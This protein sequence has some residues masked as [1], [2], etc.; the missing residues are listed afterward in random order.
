MLIRKTRK[1]SSGGDGSGASPKLGALVKH[2]PRDG[3]SMSYYLRYSV[4]ALTW[5]VCIPGI[6]HVGIPPS[7]SSHATCTQCSSVSTPGV[8]SIT[9]ALQVLEFT[10]IYLST[11][12]PF[13][14]MD[15]P[16][17][18][19]AAQTQPS[20]LLA[21]HEMLIH[22]IHTRQI[23]RILSATISDI[24]A[25]CVRISSS[26]PQNSTMQRREK[27]RTTTI[28]T[29]RMNCPIPLQYVPPAPAATIR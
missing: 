15:A 6:I 9:I 21:N 18:W 8:P 12:W 10:S 28:M 14:V 27:R 22:W 1:R 25:I 23:A 11:P 17:V 24:I 26:H 4:G 2:L 16:E 29:V 3:L 7:S 19:N 5:A 13:F 20:P